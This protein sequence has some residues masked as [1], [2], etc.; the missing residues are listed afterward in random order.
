M[1]RGIQV[2]GSSP[3]QWEFPRWKGVSQKE[4]NIFPV[5]MELPNGKGTFQCERSFPVG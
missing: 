1:G 3:A 2:E 5:G 4:R